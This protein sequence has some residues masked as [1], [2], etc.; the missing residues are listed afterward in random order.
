MRP[1]ADAALPKRKAHRG[2]R[3]VFAREQRR[4]RTATSE[5]QA[6]SGDIADRNDVVS[7]Q[8]DREELEYVHIA[9]S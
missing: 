7:N 2:T 5:A 9:V 4:A 3:S 1:P 8:V 6:L